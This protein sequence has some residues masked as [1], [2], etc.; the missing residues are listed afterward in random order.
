MHRRDYSW[1][2]APNSLHRGLVYGRCEPAGF[3]PAF[4][5]SPILVQSSSIYELSLSPSPVSPAFTTLSMPT[6]PILMSSPALPPVSSPSSDRD[7][8]LAQGS[9]RLLEPPSLTR[10]LLDQYV[11]STPS[12]ILPASVDVPPVP[13]SI[14]TA[15]P[16]VPATDRDILVSRLQ[17]VDGRRAWLDLQRIG[18]LQK[19]DTRDSEELR[20]TRQQLQEMQQRCQLLES[21]LMHLR[22]LSFATTEDGRRSWTH[23]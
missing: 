13:S 2:H 5:D 22:S 7:P 20:N 15:H 11:P 6:F 16:E 3:L 4:K 21:Q 9:P 17:D 12:A 18:I 14:P 8:V 23:L 10:A 19:L 1:G